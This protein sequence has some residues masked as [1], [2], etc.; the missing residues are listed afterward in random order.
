MGRRLKDVAL[1]RG[2]FQAGKQFKRNTLPSPISQNMTKA[3]IGPTPIDIRRCS[4]SEN[5]G[6][7]PPER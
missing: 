7:P 2:P 1:E 6:E 4:T 5:G 3:P